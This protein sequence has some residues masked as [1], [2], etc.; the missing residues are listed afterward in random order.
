[1]GLTSA[2]FVIFVIYELQNIVVGEKGHRIH[3]AAAKRIDLDSENS[4]APQKKADS[5]A[6][7]DTILVIKEII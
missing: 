6:G 3:S 1:M 2:S 4:R 5:N 7:I